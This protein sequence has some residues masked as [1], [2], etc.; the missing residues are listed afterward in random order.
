MNP[1]FIVG[2]SS[3]CD[4]VISSDVISRKHL[5]IV[6]TTDE[7]F[8]MD[9]GSANGTY[10]NEHKL[11][12][13]K[14]FAVTA[15]SQLRLGNMQETIEIID[16]RA[17]KNSS[18][19]E[20]AKS[21][22]KE[23][24]PKAPPAQESAKT[25]TSPPPQVPVK[26]AVS[27]KPVSA[28]QILSLQDVSKKAEAII[29]NAKKKARDII[30]VA[31]K[32]AEKTMTK[33]VE[34]AEAIIIDAKNQADK[35]IINGE[36]ST[37]VIIKKAKF[38]A[39]SI[40]EKA[41]SQAK[42]II[43]KSVIEAELAVAD[44][45]RRGESLVK[46]ER[47]EIENEKIKMR[48]AWFEEEKKFK[49]ELN[50]KSEQEKIDL[51]NALFEEKEKV[52]KEIDERRSQFAKELIKREELIKTEESKWSDKKQKIKEEIALLLK[53]EEELK[54][55][56][57]QKSLGLRIEHENEK[58]KEELALADLKKKYALEMEEYKKKEMER[59]HASL[60]Q[61]QE[62]ILENKKLSTYKMNYSLKKSIAGALDQ[63]LGNSLSQE[64]LGALLDK[65]SVRI[66]KTTHE[67]E[68][69]KATQA[70]ATSVSTQKNIDKRSSKIGLYLGVTA[71]VIVLCLFVFWDQILNSLKNNESFA[72]LMFRQMQIESVYVPV[73]TTDWKTS[74]YERVLY[75]KDYLDFKTNPLYSDK[76]TQHLTNVE[77]AR[78]LKLSE[79]DMIRFL[80][81]EMNLVN[82]LASLKNTI[83]ARQLDLGLAKLKA[84]E[85]DANKDFIKILKSKENLQKI[86]E[87]EKQFVTQHM[88]HM[89]QQR[90]PSETK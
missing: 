16:P 33:A 73:Q 19:K 75:L 76:W 44:G 28:P 86:N 84:A 24:S 20:P 90:L 40:L 52:R 17:E 42:Q 89:L 78:L 34:N 18:A 7:V 4:I 63:Q 23:S 25:E 57:A 69:D 38:D 71:S 81:R 56:Y 74:Y 50:K 87:W 14:L 79:D 26:K 46:E 68:E 11:D 35:I 62:T 85:D 12:S 39:D 59:I 2:R 83:D 66:E 29:E 31:E 72:K 48:E 30:D 32:D 45:R 21:V 43:D 80:A 9:M 51:K 88:S 49:L 5:K 60:Q 6:I 8:V 13:Q 54:S 37:K 53:K 61:E 77:N 1:E 27:H 64:D 58:S 41:N 82:Q 67:I 55:S 15:G 36:E 47:L 3:D 22:K 10:L 70:A 65:I